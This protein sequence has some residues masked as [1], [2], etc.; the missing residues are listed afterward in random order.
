MSVMCVFNYI[1]EVM[2]IASSRAVRRKLNLMV[3]DGS[4]LICKAIA[5]GIELKAI[6]CSRLRDIDAVL[7]TDVVSSGIKVY[8]LTTEQMK[9]ARDNA[10]VSSL[11]GN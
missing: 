6:Y 10:V 3:L 5:C 2:H 11:F 9:L 7:S 4:Q 1:R 8:Q